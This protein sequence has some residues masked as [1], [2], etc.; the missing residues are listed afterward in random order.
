MATALFRHPLG[1]ADPHTAIIPKRKESLGRACRSSSPR[2]SCA[3][4]SSASA[5]SPQVSKRA[6]EWLIAG[7][8]SER[9]VHEGSRDSWPMRCRTSKET[10]VAAVIQ[11]ALIP[12]AP[13]R[14]AQPRRRAAAR[15]GAAR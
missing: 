12:Q 14:T 6:G 4:T 2:T 11:E 15:R 9:L 13:G 10:D 7:R 3:R 8:H 1:S 5:S